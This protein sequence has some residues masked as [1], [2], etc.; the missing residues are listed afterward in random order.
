[1]SKAL[2]EEKI[3]GGP[4]QEEAIEAEKTKVKDLKGGDAQFMWKMIG[5]KFYLVLHDINGEA[6][7]NAIGARL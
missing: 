4:I 3:G 1:M 7:N 2:E 6:F 5:R